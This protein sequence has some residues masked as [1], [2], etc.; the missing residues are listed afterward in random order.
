M[1]SGLHGILIAVTCRTNWIMSSRAS[2]SQASATHSGSA[3]TSS[4]PESTSGPTSPSTS[5]QGPEF[6]VQRVM[7]HKLAFLLACQGVKLC[8]G[9]RAG[10]TPQQCCTSSV[11]RRPTVVVVLSHVCYT[12]ESLQLCNA[13]AAGHPSQP[14]SATLSLNLA[15]IACWDV[16]ALQQYAPGSC[17]GRPVAAKLR[18]VPRALPPVCQCA[19]C[20]IDVRRPRRIALQRQV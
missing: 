9:A 12:T 10:S 20:Q 11:Y 8:R 15:M 13:W 14:S 19:V 1:L 6:R 16:H 5:L 7:P 18:V 3:S 2:T 17:G 4:T